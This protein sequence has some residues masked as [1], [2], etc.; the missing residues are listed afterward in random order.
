MCELIKLYKDKDIENY[1]ISKGMKKQSL[2]DLEE[3]LLE[4]C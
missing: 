4:D 2:E 1:L 3:K